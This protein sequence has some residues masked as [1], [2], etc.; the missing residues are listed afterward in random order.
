MTRDPSD[1]EVHGPSPTASR[2]KGAGHTSQDV[3]VPESLLE[4]IFPHLDPHVVARILA[5]KL[6]ETDDP[7]RPDESQ[8]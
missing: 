2:Q 6:E 5:L 4:E 1:G 8:A 3:S 7:I